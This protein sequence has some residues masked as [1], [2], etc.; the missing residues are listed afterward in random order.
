MLKR[1]Q[2]KGF[3]LVELMVVIAIV[4]VLL[5]IAIPSFQGQGIKTRRADGQ[6]KLL[7]IQGNM[8]RYIFDNNTYP[9]KLS[10]MSAYSSDEVLSDEGHYKV[11]IKA[12]TSSCPITSCYVLLATPQGE[13]AKDGNLELYSNG[14]KVGNW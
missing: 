8:E 11:K 4:G 3:S 13:Q 9:S 6:A 7:E 12:A 5:A 14:K 2:Q 10:L 1:R